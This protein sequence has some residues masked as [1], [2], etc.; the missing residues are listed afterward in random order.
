MTDLLSPRAQYTELDFPQAMLDSFPFGVMVTD[1]NFCIRQLNQWIATQTQVK[2]NSALNRPLGEVFPELASRNLLEAYKLVLHGGMPLTLSNRIHRYFFD[3]PSRHPDYPKL[4]QTATITPIRANNQV[5]GMVTIIQDVSERVN[6]ESALQREVDKLNLL[7]E[8]DHTISTLDLSACL[9][10]IVERTWVLFSA[11]MAALYLYEQGRLVAAAQNGLHPAGKVAD[12]LVAHVASTH[13]PEYTFQADVKASGGASAGFQMAAPLIVHQEC[14]GVLEVQLAQASFSRDDDLDLLSAIATRAAIAIH[15]ARLHASERTQR[16]LADS[17]RQIGLT[18]SSTLEL[19]DVL[20]A[21]LKFVERVVPFDAACL[22]LYELGRL[23]IPRLLGVSL[24]PSAAGQPSFEE[25]IQQSVLVRQPDISLKPSLVN[26]VNSVPDNP[27]VTLDAALV[28]QA[29]APIVLRGRLEGFL[30]LARKAGHP[31]LERSVELLASFVTSAGIAID[32]ARLYRQQQVLA[33]TDGLTG[34]A[35]RRRFDDELNREIERS[36]RYDRPLSLVLFDIDNF[37]RYNDT[38][39]HPSGD[40][41]LKCLASA[42]RRAVRQ[43]DL[44]ARY[45][46]E[47]FAIILPEIGLAGA[48]AAAERIRQAIEALHSQPENLSG[49]L[50]QAPVTVS[51]GVSCVP[52]HGKTAAELIHAADA[53]LYQAK[54]SGKNRTVAADHVLET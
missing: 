24:P 29:C 44:A 27:F 18:L 42:V 41:L 30:L 45:G 47:E 31:F 2:P 40:S 8:I 12:S 32:N 37:K 50:V 26:D 7:H 36:L 25:L 6:I 9:N 51:L 33:V 49:T 46:G 35:N 20:D 4:P 1:A 23:S 16:E 43:V 14:I 3:I 11:Q 54:R 15:N 39:G 52:A 53:A 19:E 22:G 38:F 28:N 17:L 5:A 10:I 48:C 21:I 13:R 34:L